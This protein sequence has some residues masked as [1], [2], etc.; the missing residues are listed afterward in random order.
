MTRFPVRIALVA[1]I[2]PVTLAAIGV[3]L[4]LAWLPELPPTV[5]THWGFSGTPDAFGPSWTMPVLLAALGALIPLMFGV[6]LGRTVR[7]AG[8]TATQK[9]LAAASLFAVTLVSIIVTASVAIQRGLAVGSASPAILPV[10][11]V[12]LTVALVL[13]AAG[14]FLMPRAV[15]GAS[16]AQAAP[17]PIRVAPG[18]LVVWVGHARFSTWTIVA[19]CLTVALVTAVIAFVIA[20]RGAWPLAIVPVVVAVAVLGTASWRVRVDGEGLTVRAALGWPKFRV[21]LDDI[22]SASTSQVVPLGEFGGYGIRW[23][24]GRRLGVVTRGGEALEVHRRDGRAVV[25]TVDDAD[26]AAGLLTALA[27]RSTK[28]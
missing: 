3:A 27:A 6:I 24:L 8:P 21:P 22:A 23:G 11:A 26:T 13:A 7:P 5:A 19:L 18:E 10:F 20:I 2:V 4:Q 28:R 14:W 25:V 16:A 15:S 1:V 17:A 12:G 9:L